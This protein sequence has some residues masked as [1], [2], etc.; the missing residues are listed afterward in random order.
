MPVDLNRSI[1]GMEDLLARTIGVAVEIRTALATD[2][3]PALVDPNQLELV[4][5]NLALNARDAMPGGGT[6][7]IETRNVAA[8]GLDPALALAAG[9]YVAVAVADTGT[10]MPEEVAARA[11]E[12]FFTTKEPGRGSGLGLSQVYG[13]A[14]QSGGTVRIRSAVG[15]GTMVELYLPR[16][17]DRPVAAERGAAEVIAGS[18]ATVIVLDDE[19]EVREVAVAHLETLGY[20]AI[21]APTGGAALALLESSEPVDLL[22]VDYAMPG[23][24]GIEIMREARRRRPGL[25]MLLLTG[26]AD[27]V[28]LDRELDAA[29]VLRKPYRM[30]ELASRVEAVLKSATGPFREPPANSTG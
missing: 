30:H 8:A 16:A 7:S 21:E 17:S 22:I 3:W 10:G 1:T 28:V 26:Y 13:V 6:L 12:P 19:P 4:V 5:L 24:S 2:L 14:R 15:Q 29:F 11:F 23:Q 25:P 20:R 18:R 27:T 9:D